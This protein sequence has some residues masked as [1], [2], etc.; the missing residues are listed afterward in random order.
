M[1]IYIFENKEHKEH[2]FIKNLLINKELKPR[3]YKEHK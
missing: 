3:T 1:Y 2:R